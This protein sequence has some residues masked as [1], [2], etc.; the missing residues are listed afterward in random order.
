MGR[1]A[2]LWPA[3]VIMLVGSLLGVA[4]CH[5]AVDYEEDRA[6]ARFEEILSDR[7]AAVERQLSILCENLHA[8]RSFFDSSK[9]VTRA[10][11]ASFTR[12]ILERHR[13]IQAMEWIPRI[14]AGEREAHEQR[15]RDEGHDDY[16]IRSLLSGGE[17]V[18]APAAPAYYPV[19][20]VEP[21][22]GNEAV[23]GQDL[24][25]QFSRRK[26]LL[27]AVDT[28]SMTLTEPISFVQK[29]HTSPGFLGILPVYTGKPET[30]LDR[31][32]KLEGVIVLAFGAERLL[33]SAFPPS[34]TSASQRNHFR[35][36][37]TNVQGQTMT[38]DVTP[39]CVSA[40]EVFPSGRMIALGGQSWMLEG[41]PSE[42]FLAAQVS[43]QPLVHGI[44]MTVLWLVLGTLFVTETRRSREAAARSHDRVFRRV[45]QSLREGVIVA[46]EKGRFLLFN[47]AAGK[48]FGAN[49][50]DDP[51]TSWPKTCEYFLPDAE[52]PYPEKDLPFSRTIRGE[53]IPE[54][55]M[56]LRNGH[57]PNGTWL[58]VSG[59]PLRSE[60]GEIQGGV[61]VLRDVTLDVRSQDTLRQLSSVVEQTADL[62]FITDRAGRIGYVN[63]AFE[64][65]TGYSK[66]EAIGQS[67]RILN[68]GK[69]DPAYYEALWSTIHA[70]RV[71]RGKTV[72]R[73]KDGR[74]LHVEQ[75]ITPMRDEAGRHTHFVSVCKDMTE[76]RKLEEQEL[77][78]KLAAEVQQRMYPR[79]AP[80]IP[81]L[82]IAGAVL[83]ASATCGDY[84]DYVSLPDGRLCIA[85]GDVSGHGLG[86]AVIMANTRA[87]L[88]SLCRVLGDLGQIITH[89]DRFL[90]ADLEDRHFVTLLLVSI[91]VTARRVAYA[92]AG[93]PPGIILD[94]E[95]RV[96]SELSRAGMALGIDPGDD[97]RQ[98]TLVE[99]EPGDLLAI[100][101]DGVT[102]RRDPDG[103]FFDDEGAVESLRKHRHEPAAEIVRG[104][105][106]EVCDFGKG[107][108]PDDDISVV[109]C[110]SSSDQS[111][112][113]EL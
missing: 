70:G 112:E 5:V 54:T 52:T 26:A 103:R 65:T 80:Q 101:T 45:C 30:K 72:N 98:E 62:I 106:Q 89:L 71:F 33:A 99:F 77:E 75:T 22:E 84:F 79:C 104:I 78:M 55:P 43:R 97:W 64:K 49:S 88:R 31:Q 85:L 67:P 81:G 35:L 51:P 32:E 44:G 91:D 109:I 47:E 42:A 102:E 7:A 82:D 40:S 74:L 76:R 61:A 92:N 95:G 2:G 38:L 39:D 57:D 29:S 21:I 59:A 27:S 18:R 4:T 83:P 11:F 66:A 19:V 58:T 107:L 34:A 100:F 1:R 86:A 105:H 10:E 94:G 9:V 17:L 63:P 20:Y 93:H 60:G 12:P 6:R 68:S 90:V 96:K 53:D 110:K 3:G 13:E 113:S 56:F 48:I 111:P 25:S 50:A 36:R 69:Q 15:L 108:E 46:D 73:R 87:Y 24:G 8:T 14:R 28:G 23:L 37:D 41:H 16:C